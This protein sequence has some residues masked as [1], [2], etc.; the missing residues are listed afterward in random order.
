VV[1]SHHIHAMRCTP[2]RAHTHRTEH[3]HTRSLAG[4]VVDLLTIHFARGAEG[5]AAAKGVVISSRVHPGEQCEW[6]M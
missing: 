2:A 6:M 1:E 5:G 3:A 4:S